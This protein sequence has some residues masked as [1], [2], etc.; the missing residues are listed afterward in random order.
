[1]GSLL[2]TG[3]ILAGGVN[4]AD[5]ADTFGVF[6]T[7]LRAQGHRVAVLRS[8]DVRKDGSAAAALGE[9]LRGVLAQLT[10]RDDVPD[11]VD[12]RPLEAW[13]AAHGGDRPVVVLVEDTECLDG[14]VLGQLI[15][16]LSEH[17]ATFPVV[18]LLG[19]ATSVDFLQGILPGQAAARLDPAVFHLASAVECLAQIQQQLFVGAV[20]HL[21]LGH[22]VLRDMQR[23]FLTHDFS[24]AGLRRTLRTALML[25]FQQQP[26]AHLAAATWHAHDSDGGA[27]DAVEAAVH[28][29]TPTMLHYARKQLKSLRLTPAASAD[30]TRAALA[31]AL[32]A[33]PTRYR[34]WA[35]G[36]RVLHCCAAAAGLTHSHAATLRELLRD[37]S[38]AGFARSAGTGYGD[39]KVAN[40]EIRVWH[41][42]TEK[43]P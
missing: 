42:A 33:A 3:L 36:L 28:A 21:M 31:T 39:A 19:L 8:T 41:G 6:A 27:A 12:M 18:M 1:V 32:L 26:L 11:A 24:L 7:F 9:L 38:A 13:H 40:R 20:P 4:S 37:A 14:G 5:H 17:G 34:R 43:G 29:L 25:H 35:L 23:H 22:G 2:Q 15:L 10:R 30:A 16:V